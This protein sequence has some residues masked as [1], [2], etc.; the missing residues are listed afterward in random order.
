MLNPI[1]GCAKEKKEEG[2]SL[3]IEQI[4]KSPLP[5]W[6]SGSTPVFKWKSYI[7][8]WSRWYFTFLAFGK[9]FIFQRNSSLSCL[10]TSPLGLGIFLSILECIRQIHQEFLRLTKWTPKFALFGI[11]RIIFLKKV[12]HE[13]NF[14]CF[15]MFFAQSNFW[16][17][18]KRKFQEK[19][20]QLRVKLLLLI[21]LC[22]V[23]MKF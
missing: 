5:K 6:Y 7:F 1:F 13:T 15:T 18:Q 20:F 2:K 12:F 4:L 9:N 16:L 21:S 10:P 14:S 3:K 19:Y 23:V 17:K 22:I 11:T 8:F